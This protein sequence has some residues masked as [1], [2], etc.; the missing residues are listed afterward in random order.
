MEKI[1]SEKYREILDGLELKNIL[2]SN[3]KAS[4]KHELFSE[5]LTVSIKD[6]SSYENK[7]DE[8]IIRNTYRLTAKNK[9][10]KI[11]LKIEATYI[12]VFETKEIITDNFFEVYE[13]ISLPLNVW[14]FFRELVN[15]TTAR[16]NIPPI[17]LPLL[18]R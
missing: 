17:T 10:R 6:S 16:M 7:E 15:S 4:I 13:K 11:A 14:P 12:L 2:M 8:V 1:S 18:K 9:E 3:L 5:G